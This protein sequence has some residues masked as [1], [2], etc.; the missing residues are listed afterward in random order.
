MIIILIILSMLFVLGCKTSTEATQPSPNP[1]PN[2]NTIT[3]RDNTFSPATI[4]V[5]PGT[6]ITWVYNGSAVHTVTSGTRNNHT[7]LFN[8]G[9]LR[10]GNTFQFTFTDSGTYHYHCH[11][12][13]GM[14]AVVVVR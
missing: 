10:N 6:T 1:S 11:Y 4:T 8:S 5:D 3:I 9:D 12:H 13:V 14:D 7:G 2:A